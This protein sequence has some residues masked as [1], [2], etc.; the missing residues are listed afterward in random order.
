MRRFCSQVWLH[1]KVNQA[2]IDW[3]EFLAFRVGISMLTLIFYVL[4]ARYTTGE[5][6][7]TRWVV[8]NAFVL[9]TYECIHV[10]GTSF[11]A[12]RFNGRLRFMVASPTSKLL[13]LMYTGSWAVFSSFLTISAA[14]AAAALIFNVSFSGFN[15]AAFVISIGVTAF[16]CI[17]LGLLMGVF[18]LITDS[19]YL[20]LNA[21]A[22]LVMI[23]SGANFPV[24][25]L[26]VPFQWV[27][28]IF[29]VS[30]GISAANLYF[31]K[32]MDLSFWKLIAGE[33]SL[34]IIYFLASFLLIKT[35]ERIAIKKA[36]L[37]LF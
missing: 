32:P 7:L 3:A 20:I 27:S 1:A 22:M 8:G 26:P 36:T 23:F 28:Q 24:A 13:I 35:I 6:Y 33:V 30:R 19:M 29:P 10:V 5:M 37:E 15:A 31:N 4:I 12:E 34:G 11:S 17:G 21:A 9:C 25:Q 16:A 18:A 2:A 14:F